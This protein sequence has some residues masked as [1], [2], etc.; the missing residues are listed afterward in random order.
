VI[1]AAIIDAAR[2]VGLG[3]SSFVAVGNK[4]DVSSNDLLR[5]WQDDPATDV[6]MLY[7]ESFGNPKKFARTARALSQ[8]K[9]VVAVKV[10]GVP[11]DHWDEPD[12]WPADATATALLEQTGVIRVDNLTQMILTSGVLA[13]QPL[14]AGASGWRCS[15]TRGVRPGWPSTHCGPRAWSRPHRSTCRTRPSPESSRPRCASCTP[16][17]RSMPCW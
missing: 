17:P 13:S 11:A 2:R 15:P 10:G 16:G 6:V 9:P 4:A 1:G 8:H 3:I 12:V 5:Y 7:L 14:P